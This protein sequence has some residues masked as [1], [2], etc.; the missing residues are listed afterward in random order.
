MP[1]QPSLYDEVVRVTYV[2]LGPAANRFVNR[3]ITNHLRKEPEALQTGDL[4]ELI[5]WMKLAMGFLTE[6]VTMIEA[7]VAKLEAL[8]HF[9]QSPSAN[10]VKASAH[11]GKAE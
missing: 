2:Y 9:S 11:A 3:Q 5:N 10:T 8:E 1:E 6:D 4:P 7:Y